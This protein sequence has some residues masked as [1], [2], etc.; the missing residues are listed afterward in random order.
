MKLI[1][2]IMNFLLKRKNRPSPFSEAVSQAFK[3]AFEE[4]E[5]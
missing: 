5:S 2:L 1:K 4:M 3:E